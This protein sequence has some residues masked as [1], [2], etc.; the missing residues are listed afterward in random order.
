MRGLLLDRRGR[1]HGAVFR[2]RPVQGA[3]VQID[4]GPTS[5]PYAFRT[6]LPAGCIAPVSFDAKMFAGLRNGTALRIKVTPDSGGNDMQWSVSLKGFG[7]AFD[8]LATFL[9]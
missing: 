6:C 2:P 8:R 9:K 7:T 5:V 4:D 3:T 1:R